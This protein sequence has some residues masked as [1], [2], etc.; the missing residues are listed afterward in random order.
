MQ[1]LNTIS[2]LGKLAYR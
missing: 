2:K 1:A